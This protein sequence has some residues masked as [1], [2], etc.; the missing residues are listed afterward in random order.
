[1]NP[2][3]LI[4]HY[5]QLRK[6]ELSQD[7]EIDEEIKDFIYDV[8]KSPNIYT[9]NSCQGHK[10]SDYVS[11][12]Y[13]GFLV[14][15]KGWTTFWLETLPLISAGNSS[16]IGNHQ[17]LIN[18]NVEIQISSYQEDGIYYGGILLTCP[19]FDKKEEF[20]ENVK[21]AFKQTF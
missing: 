1:M 12:P 14:N 19:Y 13:L 8:N 18:I 3:E 15:E 11:L 16:T 7:I 20:W 5:F 9:E 10:H 6:T 2:K 21:E 17:H 4:L